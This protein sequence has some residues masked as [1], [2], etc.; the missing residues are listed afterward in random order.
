LRVWPNSLKAKLQLCAEAS[1]C[2]TP[3]LIKDAL[4]GNHAEQ[5]EQWSANDFKTLLCVVSNRMVNKSKFQEMALKYGIVVQFAMQQKIKG[6]NIESNVIL[7]LLTKAGWQSAVQQGI[8]TDPDLVIAFDAGRIQ[9]NNGIGIKKGDHIGSH[10]CSFA[11]LWNGESLCWSVPAVQKGEKFQGNYMLTCIQEAIEAFDKRC[12]MKPSYILILRDGFEQKGQK[13]DQH[14]RV[15]EFDEAAKYLIADG[16]KFDLV[17]VKKHGAPRL[18]LD[19]AIT[20]RNNAADTAQYRDAPPGSIYLRSDDMAILVS[21]QA[22]AGGSALPLILQRSKNMK[23]RSDV[24][25]EAICDYISRTTGLLPYA[26]KFTPRLP[27]PLHLVDR[28]AKWVHRTDPKEQQTLFANLSKLD[29]TKLFF[30]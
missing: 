11:M 2:K 3:L 6:E 5:L 9:L 7:G 27:L 8:S 14:D 24:S 17:E 23:H 28:M 12:G 19:L 1:G 18:M 30:V 4:E 15:G 10:G 21:S 16:I 26:G 20:A 22:R 25:F 13:A 29:R